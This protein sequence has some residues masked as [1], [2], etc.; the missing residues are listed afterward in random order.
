MNKKTKLYIGVG[1]VAV[2]AY[3]FWDKSQKAKATATTE[4]KKQLAGADGVFAN[5]GG[6]SKGVPTTATDGTALCIDWHG[7]PNGSPKIVGRPS[8]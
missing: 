4:V 1:V 7:G 6:C 5:A 3:Y 8:K 2:A